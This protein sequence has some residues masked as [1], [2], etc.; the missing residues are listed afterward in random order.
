MSA[1]AYRSLL[2]GAAFEVLP[3]KSLDEQLP[4]L[5][6]GARVSVTCSPNKGIDHTLDICVRLRNTGFVPV[7]HVAARMVESDHHVARIA[8]TMRDN[9]ITD[10]FVVGGDAETPA[11]PCPDGETLIR[12]LLHEQH[13]LQRIG[14]PSYP[15]G[16]A[17]IPSAALHETLHAK[18]RLI[19]QAGLDGWTSTQMCF[20]TKAIVSWLERER[21]AGLR[22]PV[23]LGVPGVVE[24]TRLMKVSMTVGVGASLRFLRKNRKALGKLLTS[25]DYDPGDLLEP[26][27]KHAERLGITSLH[28]FTFN[29]LAATVKWRDSLVSE[30]RDSD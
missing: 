13:G 9:D 19:H 25:S 5:P 6:P 22:L 12:M 8:A 10:V 15:D 24:K 28:L 14:V 4:T 29:A 26:L 23:Y 7:P 16:H 20:D 17:S 21:A 18:Q 30:L 1:T 3:F 27:S 11:G 2:T